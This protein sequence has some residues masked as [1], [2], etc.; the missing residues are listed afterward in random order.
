MRPFPP[1]VR[2][3]SAVLALAFLPLA[4]A[5]SGPGLRYPEAPT[6]QQIDF[7]HGTPVA[8]PY[9]PLE[10]P[11]AP[12][13][14][15][16]I[17]AENRLT[18]RYLS[19]LPG[20][21]PIRRRLTE[22]WN[23]E[24]FGVPVRKGGR[25]FFT[26]NDGLQDQAVLYVQDEP[27]AE[28][29]V[30]LDPN[31]LSADGTV[32]LAS[33]APSEDG[34]LLAYALSSGGSDW[35]EWRV[36][37]VTTGADRPDRLVWS[38]FSG[39]AWAHDGSGFFYCRYPAPEGDELT[40]SNR[41]QKLCFHRLG[42]PQEAD[43][44]IWERPDH[45]DWGFDPEI[46]EDGRWLVIDVSQG[47]ERRNRIF[48]LDLER[49]GE[50]LA[51]FGE[52]DASYR[53]IGNQDAT[54]FVF[55]NR[56][57]PRGRIVAVDLDRP[58]PAAWREIVPETADTLRSA[59]LMGGALV[60]HY[61]HDASSLVRIHETDG[62]LRCQVE[63]PALGTVSGIS[64]DGRHGDAFFAFSSF[65][66]PGTVFRLDLADGSTEVH[67]APEVGFDP[68]DFQ[69][70][71]VWYPSKD[72]TRVPMFLVRRRGLEPNGRRPVLLYG[73]GGFN[74][75]ITPSF[76]VANLVWLEMGG[77]YAVANIRGGGEFGREW[78]QAGTVHDKQNV[79][80]DFIAAGEW[81]IENGWTD[82]SRLAIR[83]GSNGGLLVGACVNQRPDLFAAALPAVGV[84]DMLRF[85]LF[86]IG[87]AWTS[88]YG[89]SEDPEQFRT[90]LA[91]SPYH[92]IRPG[93]HYPSV[94][95]TTGDHDDRVVPAHSFKYAAALQKAQGGRR[96]I[97]IRIETR[98]GHGAGKP[99]SK[100]IAEYAD[101]W[102]FLQ[103]ELG[104]PVPEFG[105]T[106]AD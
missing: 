83:G 77:V 6:A 98:A 66:Y 3:A 29:R 80:D 67:F 50:P 25:T 22:L 19:R 95:V 78:H 38:K 51:L 74:I 57:A 88:D 94:L 21:E 32:A 8:D 42:D 33:W 75:P 13:T 1:S 89:S 87:W 28:P 71:Q 27:G 26:R 69:V 86:T 5:C 73:Y 84:M 41:D 17:E 30:L 60:L 47:T 62:R 100:R 63:L 79:F 106:A 61:L 76:S 36:R 52:A 103:H 104:M 54:W 37:E 93:V 23:F 58:E 101:L 7:Y 48:Y 16:W 72:G 15:A 20:R 45:P 12:A 91:Y 90:L 56:D 18:E 4:A 59:G 2:C 44:L 31:G 39:V 97:L 24:R 55:T 102:A 96:P 9:R 82:P 85:H 46:T 35:R 68:A 105:P 53:V 14:R 64:G 99:T 10:D 34:R 92:N 43:A 49:G 11:D 40:A 81:L 70:E 65:T